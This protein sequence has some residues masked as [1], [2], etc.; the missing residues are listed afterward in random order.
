MREAG[1]FLAVWIAFYSPVLL[2]NSI[3][4]WCSVLV[5]GRL[6]SDE[7][8][9][10]C[11]ETMHVYEQVLKQ[12]LSGLKHLVAC[13]LRSAAAQTFFFLILEKGTLSVDRRNSYINC[14]YLEFVISRNDC[15]ILSG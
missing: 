2:L 10:S 1:V 8:E 9:K 7:V 13:C 3:K 6:S 15:I 12:H 14:G 11:S 4:I 5:K